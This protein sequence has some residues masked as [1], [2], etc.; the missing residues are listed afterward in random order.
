MYKYF[1]KNV[2]I[3]C[4]ILVWYICIIYDFIDMLIKLG[5]NFKNCKKKRKKEVIYEIICNYIL[6][7]CF[8]E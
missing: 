8:L 7:V 3:K 2:I 4:D 5:V 6:S 1:V